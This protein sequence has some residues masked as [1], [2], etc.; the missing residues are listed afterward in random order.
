MTYATTISSIPPG[1]SIETAWQDVHSSFE[2][3]CLTAGIEALEQM[4]C[5]DAE[6]LAA[7]ATAA[8]LNARA[9]VGARPRA[10]SAFTAARMGCCEF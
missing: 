2:R 3:F 4:L 10:R 5:E 8:I 6:R 7:P 9:G 1:P